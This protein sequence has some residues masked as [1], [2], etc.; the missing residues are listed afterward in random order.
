M[1]REAETTKA[2]S[3]RAPGR[4]AP[5]VLK[6][7]KASGASPRR[8]TPATIARWYKPSEGLLAFVAKLGSATP[9]QLVLAEREGIPA[10]LL[11]DMAKSL[12]LPTTRV[13]E[14][15]GVARATAERKVSHDALLDGAEGQAALGLARLLGL[16]KSILERST[17]REAA[18]F[19][20]AEWLG[21]WIERPQP[22][23]GGQK[24]ADLLDTPT[25]LEVVSRLLGALES[26]AYL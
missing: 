22:A 9:S 19:D 7:D 17:A 5:R 24:P 20:V 12:R 18:G 21:R 10:R 8:G 4:A 14:I 23:L 1:R 3:K 15:V 11:K 13:F 16:A 6:K 26:G 25:G 2:H